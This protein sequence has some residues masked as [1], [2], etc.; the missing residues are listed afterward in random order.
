[1]SVLGITGGISTGKTSFV[2]SLRRFLPARFFD[3]DVAARELVERDPATRESLAEEF[4]AA[5]YGADGHLNRRHLRAIVFADA[6]KRRALEAIVH[7]RVRET[8][9]A[10][11]AE[12]RAGRETLLVDIP[13]LYETGG[14][15]ACDRVVVIACSPA[16]QRAR[17][18]ARSGIDAALAE[19]IISSQM[20]LTEK[21]RRA[22]YVAWNNGPRRIL[23]AQAATLAR[24]WQEQTHG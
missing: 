4:G 14:E 16:I 22:D 12:A 5:I 11:A 7:P 6:E 23:E 10:M 15:K 21:I 24:F 13:L 1:M 3:A 20:T 8:W 18:I 19:Q 9:T 17:L 2:T